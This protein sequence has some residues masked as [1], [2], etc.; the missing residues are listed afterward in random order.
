MQMEPNLRFSTPRGIPD[1]REGII[2]IQPLSA[3]N[4]QQLEDQTQLKISTQNK[5][6]SGWV[7][8]LGDVDWHEDGIGMCFLYVKHG[9]G[10]FHT[11]TKSKD[12]FCHLSP[13]CYTFFNDKVPHAFQLLTP[14]CTFMV[15]SY[16]G[17]V[18][19]HLKQSSFYRKPR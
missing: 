15:V 18:P 5:D 14:R 3:T 12:T 7:R 13:G 11:E 19:T 10:I 8:L 17:T 16:T 6:L 4:L 2:D 9:A 1:S